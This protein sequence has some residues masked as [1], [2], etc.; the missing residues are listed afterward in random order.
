MYRSSEEK[1]QQNCGDDGRTILKVKN[2]LVFHPCTSEKHPALSNEWL[3]YLCCFHL[4]SSPFLLHLSPHLSRSSSLVHSSCLCQTLDHCC[5]ILSFSLSSWMNDHNEREAVSLHGQHWC[6]LMSLID[7][8]ESVCLF[9]RTG[10][11]GVFCPQ[12]CSTGQIS[13]L[14]LDKTTNKN[15][16]KHTHSAGAKSLWWIGVGLIGRCEG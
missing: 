15:T 2:T 5:S 12:L 14:R 6:F 9:V 11:W 1:N 8:K 3:Y 10:D 7:V 4:H 13:A 16:H